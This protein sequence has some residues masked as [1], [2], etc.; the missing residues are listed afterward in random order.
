MESPP[1]ARFVRSLGKV[2]HHLHTVI[3]GLSAVE[4]GAAIKPDDLDIA[5]RAHDP[6]GS[7]REARRFLLRATLIF[8]AEEVDE[9]AKGILR[10]RAFASGKTDPGDRAARIQQ[11]AQ[12]A[13]VDPSYLPIAPLIVSHWRNRIIHRSSRA[14]LSSAEQ[15]LILG[16]SE[17][18]RSTYKGI[19]VTRLLRDFE[20][21]Q[22]TLKDVTVLLAMSIKFL[23]TVD[24][25]LPLPTTS[26]QVRLWLEA[27]GLLN[28]VLRL[29][30]ES[31]NGHSPDPRARG[32]QYLITKSSTLAHAY[33]DHGVKSVE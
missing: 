24:S 21:D 22:P 8:I 14:R 33:Y 4:T 30:K 25:T 15:E 6:I 13:E 23:R 17:T 31:A 29:E 9:Y 12:I 32:K 16:A 2:Q 3:V 5:W 18:V 26:E 27:E 28:E 7:A 20:E 10:Y 11:L 1:L 19:D